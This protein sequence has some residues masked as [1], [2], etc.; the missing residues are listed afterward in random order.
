MT[1]DY[2][3]PGDPVTIDPQTLSA[4]V[5]GQLMESEAA[6]LHAR[7]ERDPQAKARVAAWRAQD[8]ALR[9]LCREL[10]KKA[11]PLVV[12]SK[13]RSW[14]RAMAVAAGWLAVGVGLGA[15]IGGFVPRSFGVPSQA[16]AFARLADVAYAVYSP[17]VR[18]PVEVG[19]ADEAQL[20]SWLSKR[21]GQPLSAPSLQEYGY[22]LVGGRL[23][24]GETGPAA[25]FMYEDQAGARLTLYL[26]HV[27]K[28]EPSFRL[29]E[30]GD[31]RTFYWVNADLGYALSGA[32][33]EAKL[34]AIAIAV[35]G[36]LGGRP[37]SWR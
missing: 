33:S 34:H 8:V 6:A 17:E 23:L 11:P 35:C 16:P 3:N 25:Q 22:T 4:F 18:H 32:T 31:R 19:A 28:A 26:A 5:D 10:E 30:G 20:T 21:L 15:A 7:I 14:P 37:E 29:L 2:D 9:A 36:A 24:P 12:V 1:S 13:R 27:T